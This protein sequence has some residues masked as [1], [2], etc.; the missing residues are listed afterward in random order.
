MSHCIQTYMLAP[1]LLP[2]LLRSVRGALY[3]NNAPGTSTL[4]APSSDEEVAALKRRCARAVWGVIPER[5]GRIYYGANAWAW[6]R[7]PLRSKKA[8]SDDKRSGPPEGTLATDPTNADRMRP[9]GLA[10]HQQQHSQDSRAH[11]TQPTNTRRAKRGEPAAGSDGLRNQQRQE[12]PRTT[13]GEAGPSVAHD[14]GSSS[15]HRANSGDDVHD[16]NGGDDAE[17]ERV[18]AEIESGILDVFSDPYCNKHLLYSI[19]ELI[20]V[21]LMPELTERG[22]VDL[23]E[24]RLV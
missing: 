8:E 20:L 14:G 5:V 22:V 7:S 13:P 23:L 4:S 2:P 16:G 11:V 6:L 21:R 15:G 3:P 17:L 1:A 18:L 9:T 12:A 19:L 10:H 24:E